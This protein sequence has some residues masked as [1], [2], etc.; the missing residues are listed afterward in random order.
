MYRV[1]F[2]V[3]CLLACGFLSAS[4]S[5]ACLLEGEDDSTQMGQ[6]PVAEAL[7]DSVARAKHKRSFFHRVG[8]VFTGFFREFDATDSAYIEPQHYNYTVMLQNTNTYELYTLSNKNNQSVTFAPD[9]SYRMG[10]YVGWRWV[11]LGYTVDLKNISFDS[12]NTSKK[13]FDLSLYSSLLGVDLFWRETGND[14]HI[15]KMELGEGV[16]MSPMKGVD[17]DGFKSSIKGFNLYYIFNH[18]KFSYPAAYS[19]STVQRK[20]AGSALA[21]IG[22]T[23]HTLEVDWKNLESIMKEKMGSSWEREFD[24]T[25]KQSTVRYST[26]SFSGG[27]SYNWV[28]VHNWLFNA[29]LSAALSYNQTS[30]DGEEENNQARQLFSF[31]NFNIDGIGRF[32]LV[33]NN[34]RWY[35]GASC[36]IHSYNYKKSQFSTNNSFGSLNIYFGVNFGKR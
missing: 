36:I 9:I 4:A 30:S 24:N 22:F 5:P 17:F 31:S 3:F 13:E 25:I 18:R 27:Y 1:K 2:L 15:Q 33:W 10:P 23:H 28:F 29:S 20:S 21:G 32:A 35:A 11:F 26:F 19:Q 6:K 14:Y 8:D 12:H 16:D 7:A 34:T